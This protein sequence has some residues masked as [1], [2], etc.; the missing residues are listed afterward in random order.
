MKTK[1]LLS[2]L[3]TFSFLLSPCLAQVPQGFTYQ[4]IARDASGNPITNQALPVRITIQSDSL[5]GT[6]F[7]IEEHSLVTTNNF[8]LFTLILGKGVKQT[9]SAVSAF[10][11]IDWSVGTKFIVTEIN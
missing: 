5:G 3:F 11:N 10:S 2:I 7:W 9:E 8:G 6:T 1:I 4:A